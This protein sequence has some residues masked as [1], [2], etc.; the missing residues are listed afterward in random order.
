M[1]TELH[2]LFISIHSRPVRVTRILMCDSTS[3][4][5]ITSVN[6]C[7]ITMLSEYNATIRNIIRIGDVSLTDVA[8]LINMRPRSVHHVIMEILLPRATE[9]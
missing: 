9:N 6:V 1:I 3:T 7:V 5:Q 8:M 2:S 4:N